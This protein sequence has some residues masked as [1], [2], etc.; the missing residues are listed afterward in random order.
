MNEKEEELNDVVEEGQRLLGSLAHIGSAW[1]RY[2]L[3]VGRLA[4]ETSAETLQ[5]TAERLESLADGLEHDAEGALDSA[6]P[7][8]SR[9]RDVFASK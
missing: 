7:D 8:R 2:G 9:R 6:G 3:E 5:S 1:A 4:L